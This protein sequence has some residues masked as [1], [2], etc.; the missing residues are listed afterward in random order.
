MEAIVMWDSEMGMA[1]PDLSWQLVPQL[2]G[3][4]NGKDTT[5]LNSPIA[6]QSLAINLCLHF[7]VEKVR[8][9]SAEGVFGYG[10]TGLDKGGIPKLQS[11]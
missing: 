8:F 5:S 2:C 11:R 1:A 9:Q 7:I 6:L 4:H 10:L 3:L